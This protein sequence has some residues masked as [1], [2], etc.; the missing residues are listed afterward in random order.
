MPRRLLPAVLLLGLTVAAQ[1]APLPDPLDG[2]RLAQTIEQRIEAMHR[3]NQERVGAMLAASAALFP[4]EGYQDAVSRL[5]KLRAENG[6]PLEIGV[7]EGWSEYYLARYPQ[8]CDL[9][10][11]VTRQAEQQINTALQG[12]RPANLNDLLDSFQKFIEQT[13]TNPR[14]KRLDVWKRYRAAWQ[15]QGV[16]LPDSL[17]LP[18][19]YFGQACFGIGVTNFKFGRFQEAVPYLADAMASGYSFEGNVGS[20]RVPQNAR[21]EPKELLR[22]ASG[23]TEALNSLHKD[24]ITDHDG[25]P[26]L[27][28]YY[29]RETP[30]VRFLLRDYREGVLQEF[31]GLKDFYR[32]LDPVLLAGFNAVYVA[33][34]DPRHNKIGGLLQRGRGE[35]YT[36]SNSTFLHNNTDT[37]AVMDDVHM[38]EHCLWGHEV[39]LSRLNEHGTFL[40]AE[41]LATAVSYHTSPDG[42]K[43]FD[44]NWHILGNPQSTD[45]KSAY[46]EP[47]IFHE[48]LLLR[49][50]PDTGRGGH[51]CMCEL[52]QY[53][54]NRTT[55]E[56]TDAAITR[57]YGKSLDQLRAEF[58][59]AV[60]SGR[61][62]QMVYEA[63]GW[64]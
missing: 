19:L 21:T 63:N 55:L 46:S 64:L 42:R 24:T 28:V 5:E 60:Q 15:A 17:R 35:G 34:E 52:I 31:Q 37:P 8:A 3:R 38:I 22:Q 23:L 20:L 58:S 49:G 47:S 40:W 11:G 30:V 13:K 54:L 51:Q 41:G 1:A 32:G 25:T 50:N 33:R 12:Q 56:E 4:P 57:I 61:L 14:E 27:N 26:I 53:S 2:L 7:T 39:D 6:S 59:Q 62:R 16:D 48:F 45:R 29:D 43:Y 36:H 18:L 9:W 44:E 10:A